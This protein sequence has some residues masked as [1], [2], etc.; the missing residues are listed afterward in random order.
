MTFEQFLAE[1][2]A[3]ATKDGVEGSYVAQTGEDCWRECFDGGDT[4]E[5]AWRE[6]RWAAAE[7]AG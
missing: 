2:D 7:A 1:I 4:P 5:D 3:L 6:E